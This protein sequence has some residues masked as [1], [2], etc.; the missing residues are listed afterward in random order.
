MTTHALVPMSARA[1]GLAYD[2]LCLELLAAASLDSDPA[3][4]AGPKA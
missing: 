3:R 1:A 4:M 2:Q